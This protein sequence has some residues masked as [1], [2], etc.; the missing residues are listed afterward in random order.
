MK[1]NLVCY[2][3]PNEWILGKFALKMS[4]NLKAIG[5]NVNISYSPEREADINHHIIYASYNG[6]SSGTDTLM[7]TH[8]DSLAKSMLLKKQLNVADLGICMS[9]ETMWNLV[10]YGIDK[11]KLC[12]VNPAYDDVFYLKP[13]KIGIASRVYKD[14]RKREIF[15]KKFSEDLSSSDYSF[16]IMGAGWDEYVDILRKKG[17][18]VEYYNEFNY[19]KYVEFIYSLDYY[20]Y[21]GLD[22][23]Q[24]GVVDA[25]AAG[26]KVIAP[27]IGYHIDAGEKGLTYSFKEYDE[28]LQILVGISKERKQRS[29]AI[30]SWNWYEYTLKH[31]EIWDY[32]LFNKNGKHIY[33][34][35]KHSNYVDGLN[36]LIL[37]NSD[38]NKKL[39]SK[40]SGF[41]IMLIKGILSHGFHK[42]KNTPPKLL[43]KKI[44]NRLKN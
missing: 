20:L 18:T 2:E 37:D 27:L 17:F 36:S 23:G 21:T 32:L 24:M 29:G 39:Q 19:E 4:E 34:F 6:I 41:K 14:G 15:L 8:I 42:I 33:D 30:S 25:I 9:D 1:I 10:N 44:I 31:L 13:L 7:I 28:L 16:S 12:Y 22:E 11:K 5:V 26:K 40:K 38:K 43:V 35:A 3:N